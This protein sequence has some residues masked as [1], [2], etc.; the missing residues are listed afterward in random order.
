[1]R[2]TVSSSLT[3]PTKVMLPVLWVGFFV[4]LPILV[5]TG[6]LVW[7]PG[8]AVSGMQILFFI[9]GGV[10]SGVFLLRFGLRLKRVQMDARSLYV[11]NF[12]REAVIPLREVRY[13]KESGWGSI[14]PVTISLVGDSE[15]GRTI[16]L[17]PKLMNLLPF[18]HHPVVAELRVAVDHALGLPDSSG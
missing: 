12:L 3:L 18:S 9:L 4:L 7:E 13:V 8:D 17:L 15:F 16:V 10:T 6:E 1:V 11:S 5:L 2:E 14:R